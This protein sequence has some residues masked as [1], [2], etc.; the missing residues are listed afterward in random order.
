MKTVIYP[1]T[2]DPLTTGH[3]DLIRRSS[4][5]FPH[6]VVAVAGSTHKRPLFTLEERVE[7]ARLAV[8]GL[9]QAGKI[10]VETF[11]GLLVDYMR[12]RKATIALRGLRAIS[13]FDYEFQ[14]AQM[15]RKLYSAYE[16]IY[17]MPDE[18]YTYVSSS[19]V[20][21]VAALG[22][23]VS[24]LVPPEIIPMLLAKFNRTP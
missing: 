4:E 10:E 5:N 3:L 17:M 11:E 22:G 24:D 12:S 21:E 2:F 13:D 14:Q 18:R 15:N 23:D 9:P 8:R 7:M 16:I 6:I 20:K 1:G 19:L